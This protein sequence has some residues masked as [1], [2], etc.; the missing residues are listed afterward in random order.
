[1]TAWT[2]ARTARFLPFAVFVATF[3]RSVVAPMLVTMGQDFDVDL[4]TITISVSVYLLAYGL[5]QPIWGLISD[6]LG[7][8]ATLRLALV[9]AAAMDLVSVIPMDIGPFIGVRAL[10][11]ATMAGV[12]PTAVIFLGDTIENPRQRQSSIA[13]LQTGVALGLSLGTIL[14]GIGVLVVGWQAFFVTTAVVCL[15]LA[16]VLRRSPNPRP[17][18]DRLPVLVAFREV[19]RNPW[20]WFLY[21]LVFLEA[22]AL[23]GGFNLVPAALERTGRSAA[24]AG[25]ATGSYGLSVLISSQVVRRSTDRI[26]SAGFLLIGG[27]SASLGFALLI[28][29]VNPVSVLISC[30]LQGIAWV[31]MHTTL[32]TWATTLSN[33]AR[34]MAVSLFAGFMFLGNGVG[35]FITGSLLDFRG[36][37][38]MFTVVTAGTIVLTVLSVQGA[39]RYAHRLG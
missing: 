29:V 3:D 26:S 10:A 17:G 14:G 9:L 30:S 38:T 5:A 1:M 39:R 12:F 18:D 24:I 20:A 15:G 13:S 7:R 16:V 28:A 6:R 32:Q 22:A 4:T 21:G 2:L 31:T 35:A 37:A 34:A 25:L 19:A 33:A 8:I 36:A 27:V 11:G 23:L